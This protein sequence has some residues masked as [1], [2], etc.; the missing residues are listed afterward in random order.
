MQVEIEHKVF[1]FVLD[2]ATLQGEMDAVTK[3]G[4][5]V[6]PEIKPVAVYHMV[7]AKG[8]PIGAMGVGASLHV[9]DSKVGILK[10]NGDVHWPDGKVSKAG[11]PRP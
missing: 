5:V 1:T 6:I 10:P 7:R 8:A 4:W 3:E 2:E 11:E 9:D